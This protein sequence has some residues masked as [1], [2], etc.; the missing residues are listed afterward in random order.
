MTVKIKMKDSKEEFTMLFGDSYK[1]YLVQIKEFFYRVGTK[2]VEN[3]PCAEIEIIDIQFSNAKWIGWGGLKWVSEE[4][5]QEKYNR[6]GCQSDEPDNPTPRKYSDISFS[7]DMKRENEIKRF[8]KEYYGDRI[9]ISS[10]T[11]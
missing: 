11:V 8:F 3:K 6:E 5:I 9:L 2:W 10:A 7:Y 1:S 4:N